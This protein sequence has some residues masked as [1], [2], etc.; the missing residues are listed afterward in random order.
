MERKVNWGK[1]VWWMVWGLVLVGIVLA[2]WL[3]FSQ[4][5]ESVDV[6]ATEVCTTYLGTVEKQCVM[7]YM[8]LTKGE[9]VERASKYVMWVGFFSIDGIPQMNI[10]PGGTWIYFTVENDRVVG[11]CF[12]DT[13]YGW[14]GRLCYS[15][16]SVREKVA[17]PNFVLE[18]ECREMPEGTYGSSYY[19]AELGRTH[20]EIIG[21]IEAGVGVTRW[22][23][24]PGFGMDY[25]VPKV[26][27]DVPAPGEWLTEG[28][29]RVLKEIRDRYMDKVCFSIREEWK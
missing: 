23:A 26:V 12:D 9:A 17:L 8:G 3:W 28:H 7:D 10:E 1:L 2:I 16:A 13:N 20:D 4:E 29:M 21:L 27:V 18:H 15:E 6:P 11:V 19:G 24:G 14:E 22:P 25:D 5:D